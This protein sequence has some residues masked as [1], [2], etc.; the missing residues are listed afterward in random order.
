MDDS[1]SVT[2]QT[3]D[4]ELHLQF[5]PRFDFK[6]ALV[7]EKRCVESAVVNNCSPVSRSTLARHPSFFESVSQK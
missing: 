2:F 6:S 7:G 3:K 1:S 5:R 4:F